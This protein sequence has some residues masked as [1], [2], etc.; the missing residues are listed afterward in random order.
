MAD[1]IRLEFETEKAAFARQVVEALAELEPTPI[2][3]LGLFE[4]LTG[5]DGVGVGVE[6]L[7]RLEPEIEA[8]LVELE[9]VASNSRKMVGRCLNLQPMAA[10]SVPSG[11]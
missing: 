3:A 11:F 5:A 10:E 1:D 6:E 7:I 9:D 4:R 8:A 2:P